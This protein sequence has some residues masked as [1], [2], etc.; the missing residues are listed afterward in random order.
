MIADE[1]AQLTFIL[2]ARKARQL[3]SRAS[4]AGWLHTTALLQTR[5]L[6]RTQR[7]ENRKRHA[8]ITMN[9]ATE[10]SQPKAWQEMEPVLDAALS[11]LRQ[12]DRE[13]ILLRF[14]RGLP[15][16]DV[17]AALGIAAE[18]A[19]KRVDRALERLRKQLQRRGCSLDTTACVSALGY[20]A[21][22]AQTAAS[23]APLLASHALKA[24]AVAGSATLT[25]TTTV[26][27]IMTK[28]TSIAATAALL[29][30][31]AGAVLINKED[32]APN[33][34]GATT[35][36]RPGRPQGS[37]SS[38]LTSNNSRSRERAP[39][40]YPD[41]VEKY[42]ESRTNLSKRIV[43]NGISLL[44][45]LTFT[46]EVISS[47]DIAN[48]GVMSR[49]NRVAL[50]R[51]YKKLNLEE[52][53]QAAAAE[54]YSDFQ[55]RDFSRKK[56]SIEEIKKLT[57]EIKE[58]P[59]ALTRFILAS[60]AFKRGDSTEE[61]YKTSQAE[62][63]SSF[64][65]FES[66][67][68]ITDKASFEDPNPLGDEAFVTDFKALLTPEQAGTFQSSL[69]DEM[70]ATTTDEAGKDT[71]NIK[72]DG[73][74]LEQLDSIITSTRAVVGGMKQTVSSLKELMGNG[75]LAPKQQ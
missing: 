39:L 20:F 52:D 46:L 62:F 32:S 44:E 11:A 29:L 50:D 5:N 7:R 42:G 45:D 30:A 17:A 21:I 74:G 58:D 25:T 33:A 43:A 60:D 63:E 57:G 71:D 13:A 28:K 40:R 54:V 35:E 15:H 59:A 48:S 67:E 69:D 16:A 68:G 3:Q 55:K 41:L 1:A 4:L 65:S 47:P 73:M 10:E 6:L 72:S 23:A 27:L 26:A 66:F 36:G 34:S 18:A 70:A 51:L 53:Q 14:H 38:T 12:D 8:T 19:R 61:D 75:L 24:A 56:E 49:E 9:P 2:L 37:E 22:D 31:G 64:A